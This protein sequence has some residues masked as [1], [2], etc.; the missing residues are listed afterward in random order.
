MF[1]SATNS[2]MWMHSGWSLLIVGVSLAYA[3]TELLAPRAVALPVAWVAVLPAAGIAWVA[4]VLLA[5]RCDENCNDNLVPSARE[6]GWTHWIHS[7]QWYLQFGFA[8]G[9]LVATIAAAAAF[10]LRRRAVARALAAL[11]AGCAI[12]WAIAIPF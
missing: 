7:W 1:A 11:A 5:L 10:L 6:P 2:P 12:A 8:A 3:A 9:G 4:A